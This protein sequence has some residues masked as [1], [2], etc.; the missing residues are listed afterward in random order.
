MENGNL[1]ILLKPKTLQTT[2]ELINSAAEFLIG[3]MFAPAYNG[4]FPGKKLDCLG[5]GFV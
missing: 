2:R 1:I 3:P 5:E 4:P